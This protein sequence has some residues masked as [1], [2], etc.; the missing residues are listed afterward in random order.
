MRKFLKDDLCK[1]IEQLA[2]VNETLIK[3]GVGVS[4]EQAQGVFTDCQQAAVEIGEK[5][6]MSEGEGAET[7]HLLEEYCEKVYFLCLNWNDAKARDKELKNIRTLLNKVKNA[8]LYDIPNSKKEVVF[9]PYKASMWDSLESVWKAADEDSECDAYVIPIPY[10]DKNPDGSFKEMH[11]EGDLYPDY[12]PVT[13]YE[14]YDFATRKPD[15]VF[16]H[17]PYDDGNHVTSV[18]PFFYS[19]NLKHF[20]DKLVYIPY[21]VTPDVLPEA[22]CVTS[23]SMN[24]DLV[25]VQSEDV[26]QNYIYAIQQ[27]LKDEDPKKVYEY[28][29]DKIVALGSPK[30]EKAAKCVKEEYPLPDGWK[31]KVDIAKKEHRT[32][33][34]YNTSLNTLL[35]YG[36]RYIVKLKSALEIFEKRQDVFL[37]WRPHPLTEATL[38]SMRTHL[39]EEYFGIVNEYKNKA[40]GI[41]DD[42]TNLYQALAWSDVYYGDRSSVTMLFSAMKKPVMIQS[43]EMY[44]LAF[45]SICECKG[46]YWLA[47]TWHNGLFRVDKDTYKAELISIF[48][49]ESNGKRL[50]L[51][52]VQYENKLVFIPLAADAVAV[53]CIDNGEMISIPLDKVKKDGPVKYIETSKFTFGYCCGKYVYMFP[54]TYPAIARLDMESYEI[55]YLYES[56]NEIKKWVID[57]SAFMF[58]NGE[59]H[60]GI[61]ASWCSSASMLVEF[62][63]NCEKLKVCKQIALQDKYMEAVYAEDSYWLIPKDKEAKLIQVSKAYEVLKQ[64]DLPK[65]TVENTVSYICGI[66]AEDT[67]WVFPGTGSYP[68]RYGFQSETLER[69][70]EFEAETAKKE[71][72]ENGAWKYFFAQKMNNCI[73][74]YN[75]CSFE[76]M[77]YDLSTHKMHQQQIV[78]DKNK[79]ICEELFK[80][81]LAVQYNVALGES[82]LYIYEGVNIVLEQFL[83]AVGN[84]AE[85]LQDMIEQTKEKIDKETGCISHNSV[86][87]DVYRYVTER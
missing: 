71:Q 47:T 5:I 41:F 55:V 32:I 39:Y 17:N 52:I 25:V 33:V 64:I 29:K 70:T 79:M 1:I 30:L 12:V 57:P 46:Y 82:L 40:W 31:K 26:R 35:K 15:V 50:F 2:N 58:R 7:V 78:I 66:G 44:P 59:V 6:E 16:I 14:A 76:L 23:G 60:N 67:L 13:H 20:T 38:L 48:K 73:Y 86:G 75:N 74:A 80:E 4:Q 19:K 42:T 53:Y 83:Y 22:L 21:F 56:L 49:G 51:D 45:E 43:I 84:Y 61:V 9:L 11:Y 72:F 65:G 34:C 54:S 36:E 77:K 62:D 63:M 27:V 69:I 3:K 24:A 28:I 68:I 87:L 37:W 81:L 85:I 10:Y 8:I 18:H